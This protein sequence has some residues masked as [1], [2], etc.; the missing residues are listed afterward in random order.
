MTARVG[1]Y[2]LGCKVSQYESE[3]IAEAFERKGATVCDFDGCNDIY[4]INTC[5]V[6]AES[7]RKCRQFIRRAIKAGGE[8]AVIAVVGCYSQ[9]APRAVGAIDGVDVVLGTADKLSVVD[10]TLEKLQKKRNGVPREQIISVC[11]LAGADFEPMRIERAP[12]ARAYVK[13]E[14]GCESKCTYCAIREARGPVRSKKPEEV[15]SEVEALSASGVSEVVLTGIETGSYGRDLPCEYTLADL[16]CELDRR[17]SCKRLRLGS[18]APELIGEK[19]VERVKGVGILAPH[20]H[21]SVQS[22]SDAVLRAMKRRYTA[23]QAMENIERLRRAFPHA[24]FTTDMM[25]GFPGESEED[26][27][28]SVDFARRAGFIDMHVFAYSRR[29][30]T[31][32]AAMPCQIPEDEKHRRSERL[33]RVRDEVRDGVL[34][35]I[36][37][38]GRTLSAV[39]ENLN[40]DGSYTAHSDSFAEIC[41]TV[42]QGC[43]DLRG[44]LVKVAPVSHKNGVIYG[45]LVEN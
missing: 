14:D 26:F 41:F 18:L 28:L 38:S 31:V 10:L 35:D 45:N 20:F 2:T 24:A 40:I 5:T 15:I 17:G 16:I 23:E 19:F 32:A 29:E 37:K 27:L 9:R 3:A 34:S 30:G 11:N 43:A 6:T 22:G 21:L 33:I 1:L 8:G 7:D 12:R 42:P 39:A 25:V 4:V 36:V 13:I 44:S